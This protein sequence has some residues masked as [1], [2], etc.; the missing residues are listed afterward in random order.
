MSLFLC[1]NCPYAITQSGLQKPP[2]FASIQGVYRT[3]LETRTFQ[4]NTSVPLLP[5][6]LLS[7]HFGKVFY[8]L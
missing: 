2:S 4:L 8:H 7:C 5:L 1:H 6:S 3:T